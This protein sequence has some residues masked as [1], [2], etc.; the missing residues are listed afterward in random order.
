[1]KSLFDVDAWHEIFITIRKNKLRSFLTSFSIAWGIFMLMIL[2]GS[3]NGLKNGSKSMFEESA[4]N[5]IWVWTNITSKA[6]DGYP[7]GRR[8]KLQ[9]DDVKIIK[10]EVANID[11]LSA[12]FYMGSTPFAY[13]TESSSFSIK[14]CYPAV[15]EIDKLEVEKGRFLNHLDIIQKR[16]VIV[17][18]KQVV[19]ALFKRE[20][21][22]NKMII[23]NSI[24]FRVIGVVKAKDDDLNPLIPFTT[25]QV[26]F[27]KTNRVHNIALTTKQISLAESEKL[28][29]DIRTR[30]A[31]KHHFDPTDNRALGTYNN[32]ADYKRTMNIFSAIQMFIWIIGCGTLMAGIVGVSNIML[33]IV[34]ERT[35]EIGIR[36]ALGAKPNSI[37][38]LILQESIFLTTL[39]GFIGMVAG[40]GVMKLVV[41]IMKWNNIESD[42]FVN[43]S[44]DIGIAITATIV[45]IIS[46]VVAGYIPAKKAAKISPIEALRYE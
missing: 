3:G 24:P 12:N 23:V 17:I 32:F 39:A 30:M 16:K 2:L 13:K 41:L 14:C 5:T 10:S 1:M 42:T 21:P 4:L 37:I 44:V 31:H 29:Q 9:N 43:P 6:Y 40:A 33:I 15:K 11:K 18:S 35:K 8:V 25:Y 27:Q 34:K 22:L 45:L 19:D 36:K 7:K 38:S 26:V 28:E 20:D 46:G